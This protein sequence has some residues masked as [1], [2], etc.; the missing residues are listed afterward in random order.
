MLLNSKDPMR[1]RF[2]RRLDCRAIFF[3][4]RSCD[5]GQQY[6]G[7]SCR[8]LARVQQRRDASRRYWQSA[9]G[10][11]SH[12]L[13]QRAYRQRRAQARRYSEEQNRETVTDQGSAPALIVAIS[14]RPTVARG[15]L[16]RFL[17]L[18]WPTGA[19]PAAKVQP[20]CRCC[21]HQGQFI[22][23]RIA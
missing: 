14:V 4:C 11:F 12:R 7:S 3:I 10:R 16:S 6:C 20:T 23:K 15:Q 13:N 9:E 2:C 8:Q 17:F 21:G 19:L 18:V 22:D 1:Q 5:R